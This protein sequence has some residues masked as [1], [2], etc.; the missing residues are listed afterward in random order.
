VKHYTVL[1]ELDLASDFIENHA[2]LRIGLI[3][4]SHFGVLEMLIVE[5]NQ[6]RQRLDFDF[7]TAIEQI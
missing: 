1:Y 6:P 7:S 4:I 2:K 3:F 5:T